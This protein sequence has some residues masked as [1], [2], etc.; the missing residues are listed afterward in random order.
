M[1]N[2]SFF[3][4]II[5]TVFLSCNAE[6][7]LSPNIIFIL[8]D[9]LGYADLGCYSQGQINTPEL[10]KMAAEGIRFTQ[11]Y[12]GSTVC[13]PSRCSLMTGLH[14]GN[15]R[16]RGNFDA[17]GKEVGLVE[18]S[19]TVAKLLKD[20]GYT[21][22]VIGKWGLGEEGT[23]GVPNKQGFD[24]FYG[25]LNQIHAHNA[26]PEYLW[27]NNEKVTLDNKVET[28]QEGY[29]KGFGGVAHQRNQHSHDLFTAKALEFVNQNKRK[30]FFLYLAYTLPHANNESWMFDRLGLE[31]P[32][33]F[34]SHKEW[35]EIKQA[36]A[37]MV[38][39]LDQ[40]IGELLSF[41]KEN[42]L[43]ENTL[44]VFTSDNGPH[45]EGGYKP[46][47]FDSNGKF[48]GNKRD[49][50]EGGIRV[51]MIAWWPGKISGGTITEHPSAFWDFLP[52][53]CEIAGI[54]Q[55]KNTDG[56][57]YLPTL[58]QKNN[59]RKHDYLYWEFHEQGGKQAIRKGDW[60]LIKLNVKD[61]IVNELY[62]LADDCREEINLI[63]QNPEIADS[64]NREIEDVRTESKIFRFE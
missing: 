12:A 7:Q 14:T 52:T 36:Y 59:Q 13:A 41:L 3:L 39:A 6:S 47:I 51:P 40:D 46:E 30:P 57:S 55:P 23:E 2:K 33:N 17:H 16:V 19:I 18:E 34:Y 10:D 27:H 11:H 48:R 44:V 63:E 56:I 42:N 45:A 29:A 43:D 5:F 31:T 37:S 49:L 61:V 4:I 35:S 9:D 1:Q 8:A 53:A 26:Y 38:T 50:Y 22:G 32:Q 60:K 54:N 64:L 20:A 21:T 25:Y 24:Y 28:V 58:M 62:N 15:S